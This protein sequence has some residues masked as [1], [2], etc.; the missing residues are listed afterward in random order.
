MEDR[1]FADVGGTP[2]GLGHFLLGLIMACVGGYLL[3]NRVVVATSYWSFYGQ[4]SFGVTLL[5]LLIG[6]AL[7]FWNGRSI[8][9]WL[10]T[11]A[12]ALFIFGGIIANLHIFFAPTTLFETIVMLVLLVGGLG[13][14]ARAMFPHRA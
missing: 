9:G 6:V 10:L 3:S 14:I 8:A 2:G 1:G 12:G 5:P 13:L 4:H 11:C 7:L